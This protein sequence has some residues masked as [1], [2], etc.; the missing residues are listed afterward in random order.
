[1]ASDTWSNTF[2]IFFMATFSPMKKWKVTL[3]DTCE[4]HLQKL[5]QL[6]QVKLTPSTTECAIYPQDN[7]SRLMH[8]NARV[9]I[10]TV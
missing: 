5:S 6:R 7:T 9:S 10:L 1:M 2:V 4:Y 8:I 3:G